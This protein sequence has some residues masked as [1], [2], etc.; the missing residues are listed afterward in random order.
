MPS[1]QL[2]FGPMKCVKILLEGGLYFQYNRPLLSFLVGS[3]STKLALQRPPSALPP[4]FQF[5]PSDSLARELP[6][7]LEVLQLV[8]QV[9]LLVI[10]LVLLIVLQ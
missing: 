7:S 1:P 9:L 8:I 10:Q 2:G 5:D 3:V 6:P 4:I